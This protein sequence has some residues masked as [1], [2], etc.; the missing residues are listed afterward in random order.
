MDDGRLEKLA[1]NLQLS[2]YLESI[3]LH[4]VKIKDRVIKAPVRQTPLRSLF[5]IGHRAC[6][7]TDRVTEKVTDKVTDKANDRLTK[8]VRI[9]FF[10]I[11][12]GISPH[13]NCRNLCGLAGK[14]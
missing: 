1:N 6:Q 8:K 9:A 3:R 12:T 5:L 13:N 4:K 7:W 14:H 11:K 10:F 2:F